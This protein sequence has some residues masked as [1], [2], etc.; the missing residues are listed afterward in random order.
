MLVSSSGLLLFTLSP[1]V[2]YS[3]E[4]GFDLG[5]SL[6]FGLAEL[7]LIVDLLSRR[8]GYRD[9]TI[10][11][12]RRCDRL[13]AFGPNPLRRRIN[14]SRCRGRT[15]MK[16]APALVKSEP[17]DKGNSN[18][19]CEARYHYKTSATLELATCFSRLISESS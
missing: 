8:F 9:S 4:F 10:M 6:L 11:L 5:A 13:G 18:S 17:E 19:P 7:N 3:R 16:S 1:L 14:H 15:H 2:V 12:R